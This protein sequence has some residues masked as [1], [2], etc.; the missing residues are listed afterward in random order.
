MTE[1][2][3][4]FIT[5]VKLA[6]PGSPASRF[7]FRLRSLKTSPSSSVPPAGQREDAHVDRLAA[8][9]GD[10]DHVEQVVE[11][12]VPVADRV[13]AVGHALE[14]EDAVGVPLPDVNRGVAAAE[15]GEPRS[16]DRGRGLSSLELARAAPRWSRA[17][18][19]RPGAGRSSSPASITPPDAPRASAEA[20]ARTHVPEDGRRHRAPRPAR[21]RCRGRSPPPS[22]RC[23]S[24]GCPRAWWCLD[25]G[26]AVGRDD[27]E[28]VA[29]RAD[30]GDREDALGRRSGRGRWCRPG[31]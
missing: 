25:P 6:M 15:R 8:V 19:A 11:L 20:G 4:F 10:V 7:P 3:R 29:V 18:P 13:G 14:V 2:S 21:T 5:T 27:R 30:V 23:R 1:F 28:G 17:A 31:R 26:G 24:R 16:T 9:D 12:L 22:P